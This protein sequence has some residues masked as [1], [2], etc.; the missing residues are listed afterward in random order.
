MELICN[1]HC[2]KLWCSLIHD[3]AHDE[4]RSCKW[5]WANTKEKC[6]SWSLGSR[7]ELAKGW[8]RKHFVY[9]YSSIFSSDVLSLTDCLEVQVSRLSRWN[10]YPGWSQF[11]QGPTNPLLAIP[12]ARQG[13]QE[14]WSAFC[15]RMCLFFISTFINSKTGGLILSKLG[16]QIIYRRS[17]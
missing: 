15:L 3:V 10:P 12:M 2:G 16:C 13:S 9:L 6:T 5:T 8:A 14:V 1:M 7:K 4:C 11:S 17:N